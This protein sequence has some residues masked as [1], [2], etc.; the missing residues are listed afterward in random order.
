MTDFKKISTLNGG[1]YIQ[2]IG[3]S[4]ARFLLFVPRS[5]ARGAEVAST[6][7]GGEDSMWQPLKHE[8]DCTSGLPSPKI[9]VSYRDAHPK[10]SRPTNSSTSTISISSML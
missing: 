5:H 9:W 2:N 1:Y 3:T 4:L 8:H 7:D 10:P 6:G